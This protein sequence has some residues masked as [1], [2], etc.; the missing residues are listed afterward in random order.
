MQVVR[1]GGACGPELAGRWNL[2]PVGITELDGFFSGH[3]S[4]VP[5][6]RSRRWC[7]SALPGADVA[8][9]HPAG[10]QSLDLVGRDHSLRF[11]DIS[12]EEHR[13]PAASVS[14]GERVWVIAGDRAG[15]AEGAAAV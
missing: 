10:D 6:R 2:M 15:V 13:R 11:E 12:V 3:T 14:G 9:P 5:A 7:G 4:D 8:E 1:S